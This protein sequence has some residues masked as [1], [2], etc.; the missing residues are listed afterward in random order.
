[1][2]QGRR[3]RDTEV[4]VIHPSH[5]SESY[6]RMPAARPS[7]PSMMVQGRRKRK[8]SPARAPGQGRTRQHAGRPRT[9]TQAHQSTESFLRE[10]ICECGHAGG[11]TG[12]HVG[13]NFGARTPGRVGARNRLRVGAR[14]RAHARSRTRLNAR[15]CTHAR[16]LTSRSIIA[17]KACDG[18][19]WQALR[20]RRRSRRRPHRRSCQPSPVTSAVTSAV[21]SVV[22]SAVTSAA[23]SAVTSAVTSAATTAA[24]STTTP[25]GSR[26]ELCPPFRRASPRAAGSRRAPGRNISDSASAVVFA[27][28]L[29]ARGFSMT[30][31]EAFSLGARCADCGRRPPARGRRAG[32]GFLLSALGDG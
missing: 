18:Q 22:T 7:D 8:R 25:S 16:A 12:G 30:A 2:V 13:P 20:T 21:T 32:V 11:H 15:A 26:R 10:R 24:T 23:T 14:N 9:C 4:R 19:P 6:I 31:A 17:G 5:P 1:M 3:K 29:L 27:A 28:C